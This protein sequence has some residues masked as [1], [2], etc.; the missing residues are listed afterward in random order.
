MATSS[1][2]FVFPLK[3]AVKNNAWGRL[4]ASSEVAK[5]RQGSDPDFKYD[6]ETPYAELWMGTHPNGPSVISNSQVEPSALKDWIKKNPE[7]L[8]EKVLLKFGD[9]LPFLFKVLSVNKGLSIQAHPNKSHAEKLHASQPDKY[10]DPNHKPEM[11]IALTE[12]EGLCGFR[13]IAEIAS[14]IEGI[15]ELRAV[16]GEGPSAALLNNNGVDGTTPALLAAQKACFKGLMTCEVETV[17]K[18]L[19]KLVQ[20]IQAMDPESTEFH[21]HNGELLL[22]LNTQYPGDVGCF[23]IYFL[24]RTVLQPGQAIFLEANLPHAYLDG[25]CIE[26]MACSDNVVRC[27]LTPKFKDVPTLCEMLNY[28]GKPSA[29]NLFPSVQ[30]S[31][32][33]YVTVYNPP[34]PDFAVCK[35]EVPESVS[36]YTISPKDSASI[37]LV[38]EGE[39][40]SDVGPFQ[41]GSTIFISAHKSVTIKK[42]KGASLLMFRA[43][44]EL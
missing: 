1:E 19:V 7:S 17:E 5:L 36:E 41:R 10:A 28:N 13:P 18:N 35:I 6:E 34:V 2:N 42:K 20:R 27:G 3:C 16:V 23:V 14:Y 44:C 38:I 43:Y 32:D 9:D 15:P 22:R 8:G 11:A 31:S 21:K 12:F 24:N 39:A 40:Q 30:D 26:C 29:D 25:N 4:G 37:V 33:P